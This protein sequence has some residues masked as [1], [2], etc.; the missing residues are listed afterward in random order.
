MLLSCTVLQNNVVQTS[1]CG[2][3]IVGLLTIV[4]CTVI[5]ENARKTFR[6]L[7]TKIDNSIPLLVGIEI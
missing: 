2:I 3:V 7:F 6:N 4:K 5:S 1:V